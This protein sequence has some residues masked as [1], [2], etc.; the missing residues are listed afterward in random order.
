METVSIEGKRGKENFG[1]QY[2]KEKKEKETLEKVLHQ[3]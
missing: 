1:K 2:T 3:E